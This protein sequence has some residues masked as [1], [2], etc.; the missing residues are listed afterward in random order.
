MHPGSHPAR[1]GTAGS[2]G[3]HR[4]LRSAQRVQGQRRGGCTLQSLQSEKGSAGVISRQLPLSDR[5][6]L[7]RK[8]SPRGSRS[9]STLWTCRSGWKRAPALPCP[10][11]QKPAVQVGLL[12]RSPARARASWRGGCRLPARAARVPDAAHP[13]PGNKQGC[14]RD[15]EESVQAGGFSSSSTKFCAPASSCSQEHAVHICFLHK[16]PAVGTAAPSSPW[17]PGASTGTWTG[18]G[19]P[20]PSGEGVTGKFVIALAASSARA[21]LVV[22]SGASRCHHS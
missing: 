8:L 18:Q 20:G 1:R 17:L 3:S 19:T 7:M 16:A 22:L 10:N 13:V 5:S 11:P 9:P 15:K 2:G 21:G 12:G 4:G 6:P 14:Y